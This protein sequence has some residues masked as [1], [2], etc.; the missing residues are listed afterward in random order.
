MPNTER[1]LSKKEAIISSLNN[2]K[3]FCKHVLW[4]AETM[5]KLFGQN[6]QRY[7]GST[8]PAAKHYAMGLPVK[9]VHCRNRWDNENLRIF[10]VTSNHHR[11]KQN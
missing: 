1:L 10:S 3:A 11:L 8:I 9:L 6:G 5:I 4:S 2:E 7:K